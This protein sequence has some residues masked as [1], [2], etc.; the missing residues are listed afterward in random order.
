MF[1]SNL[2]SYGDSNTIIF[3]FFLGSN[4][5]ISV[6]SIIVLIVCFGAIN[7]CALAISVALFSATASSSL[8]IGFTNTFDPSGFVNTPPMVD[9][10]LLLPELCVS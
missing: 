6:G 2:E 5:S 3:L 10:K 1:G 9:I 4:S 7:P 8:S